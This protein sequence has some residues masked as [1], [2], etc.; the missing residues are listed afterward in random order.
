MSFDWGPVIA[1][2]VNLAQDFLGQDDKQQQFAQD[3]ETTILQ[4]QDNERGR[5][6]AMDRANLA[7]QTQLEAAG[8]SADVAKKKILGDVLLQ[9][10]QGQEKLGLE[11]YRA[12]ANRPE[13]FNTAANVLAQILSR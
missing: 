2:G 9:Q 1:A 4:L 5:A 8:L 3:R 13:R 10:G 7:A 11:A 6:A 12:A